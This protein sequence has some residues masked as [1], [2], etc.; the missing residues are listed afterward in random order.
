MEEE[1]EAGK[2]EVWYVLARL[3]NEALFVV[4]VRA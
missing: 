3:E 2:E 1:E 4:C